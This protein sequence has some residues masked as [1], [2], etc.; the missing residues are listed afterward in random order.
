MLGDHLIAAWSRVQPRIALSSGEAELYAGLRGISETL[1]FVHMMREFH[2]QDWGRIIHRVDASA[3]R[4]IML[5]G[6]CGGLKHLTVKS[7]WVQEAVR[8]YLIT[9]DKVPRD[10]MNA[11]IL[12]SPSADALKKHQTELNG[13]RIEENGEIEL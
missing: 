8:E 6:G 5:R 12:A 10:A 9:T 4:A 7:L 1:W 2:T 11:H 13:F 3:C